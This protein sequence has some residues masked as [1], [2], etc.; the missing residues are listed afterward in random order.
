MR[1]FL[2][3]CNGEIT[4]DAIKSLLIWDALKSGLPKMDPTGLG[5]IL[6]VVFPIS[7][8][9]RLIMTAIAVAFSGGIIYILRKSGMI[10]I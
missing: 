9:E 5:T 8:A 4:P 10:R 7:V 3:Y 6:A 1:P 2:Q